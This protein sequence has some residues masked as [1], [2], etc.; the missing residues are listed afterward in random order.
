MLSPPL[1]SLPGK[2][3]SIAEEGFVLEVAANGLFSL[4]F[5][6]FVALP[7]S[8]LSRICRN[9]VDSEKAERASTSRDD[10]LLDLLRGRKRTYCAKGKKTLPRE[11]FLSVFSHFWYKEA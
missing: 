3:G 7:A 4:S 11:R 6:P 9:S 1:F 2:Y 8:L 10:P 5:S